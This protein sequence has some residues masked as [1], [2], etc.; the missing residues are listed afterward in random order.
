VVGKPV[1]V[2]FNPVAVDVRGHS[3]WVTSVSDDRLSRI[4][5]R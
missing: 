1:R 5:F 3:V 2:G 4:D